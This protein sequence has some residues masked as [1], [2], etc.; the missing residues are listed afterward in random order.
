M[1]E[2]GID[3]SDYKSKSF[4]EFQGMKF[5][6]VITLC[7]DANKKCVFFPG[8]QKYIHKCFKDPTLINGSKI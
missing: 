7:N 4:K 5:D 8:R 1:K 2:I 6:F 3:I